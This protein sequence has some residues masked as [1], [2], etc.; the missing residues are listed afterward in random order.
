MGSI[1]I[2]SS[3]FR[4][5][6]KPEV[7]AAVVA[8]APVALL[9]PAPKENLAL[10]ID[11]CVVD[12]FGA[13]HPDSCASKLAQALSADR[14]QKLSGDGYARLVGAL[15]YASYKG[16]DN[17]QQLQPL[18]TLLTTHATHH[19][20]DAALDR[21]VSAWCDDA[22]S[23][24]YLLLLFSIAERASTPDA[25]RLFNVLCERVLS[26]AIVPFVASDYEQ[27]KALF[28]KLSVRQ[29]LLTIERMHKSRYSMES[30]QKFLCWLGKRLQGG[31]ADEA[32]DGL[33]ACTHLW[34]TTSQAAASPLGAQI[35]MWLGTHAVAWK[36]AFRACDENC[37]APLDGWL[38]VHAASQT[39][40]LPR[41]VGEPTT[42]FAELRKRASEWA[43]DQPSLLVDAVHAVEGSYLCSFDAA[44]V[45]AQAWPLMDAVSQKRIVDTVVAAENTMSP[46][47]A[48]H[49]AVA[50]G[51]IAPLHGALSPLL[52]TLVEYALREA[53]QDASKALD[54]P[55]FAD[56][57]PCLYHTLS[58]A[59]RLADTHDQEH[60]YDELMAQLAVRCTEAQL[61][62]LSW[63]DDTIETR[64]RL[65]ARMVHLMPQPNVSVIVRDTDYLDFSTRMSRAW[66]L[67]STLDRLAQHEGWADFSILEDTDAN[68]RA[69][70]VARKQ[71]LEAACRVHLAND[72]ARLCV[73]YF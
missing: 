44:S 48:L 62:Q 52:A 63:T 28:A 7:A 25:D 29:A 6:P 24:M 5:K 58:L 61:C 36:R 71:A 20:L 54:Q 49:L 51:E 66:R 47:D 12:V 46:K 65:Y 60:R 56:G 32:V 35:W 72:L 45:M 70:L 1:H 41:L 19:L 38:L 53:S 2:M 67:R 16:T 11:E 69:S 23:A 39:H 50:F 34:T 8:A 13:H 22:L 26:K 21:H 59:L 18:L 27:W 4:R 9:A 37:F 55:G 14:V 17:I 40:H 73:A 30:T 42:L 33:L 43:R 57:E 3:F 31:T 15:S 64:N 10:L 68:T